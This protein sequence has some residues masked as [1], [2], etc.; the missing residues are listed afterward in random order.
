[1]PS[2]DRLSI[3][4]CAILHR[5]RTCDHQQLWSYPWICTVSFHAKTCSK[6]GTRSTFQ[7]SS[8]VSIF[9]R[10]YLCYK[11]NTTW[12]SLLTFLCPS[13]SNADV[14]QKKWKTEAQRRLP[15]LWQYCFLQ[16]YQISHQLYQN[17]PPVP[18]FCSVR[19]LKGGLVLYFVRTSAN[20]NET[21]KFC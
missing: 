8:N 13:Q 15:C 10:N 2:T 5:N 9:A 6:L 16:R 3:S 1:M 4:W 12:G 14:F 20:Y 17:W 11:K 18:C 21:G 7:M 19:V